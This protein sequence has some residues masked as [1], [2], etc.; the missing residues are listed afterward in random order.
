MSAI[1]EIFQT[2]GPEYLDHYEATIPAQHRK[3][4]EAIINCRT[5]A[6]GAAL[7]EC[8]RCGEPH[9]V[10]R[11]CGNRHCPNCQHHKSRQWLEKQMKRQLPTHHFMITFTVPDTLRPFVRSN[12]RLAYSAIFKASS[13]AIKKLAADEKYVGGDL[14]G[15]FGVLHTWGRQLHYHPHIHYVVPA[16]AL[17]TQDHRWHPSRIDFYLPIRALSK[18]FRA[19]FRDEMDKAGVLANIPAELWHIDW[20]VNCQPV[21]AGQHS[22]RYLAP[23][24]FKVAISD[25]RIIKVENRTVFFR[26]KKSHS[27]RWRTMTLEVMEFIRRFLHHVLPTGFMKIRYYGFMN[28]N[29]SVPLDHISALIQLAYG[30][31]VT[32]PEPGTIPMPVI[33]CALCGGTLRYRC[34]LLPGASSP[35]RPG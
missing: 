20:N 31:T 18:L 25:R 3:V 28:P 33:T 14:P 2:Y 1:K 7:Y 19:K 15:F 8:E 29:S 21:G 4:I 12:Q 30:F 11:S 34:L 26:Y 5:S 27:Q 10:Y 24:V 22:L 9:I 32:V 6:C 35:Q 17:S 13:E 16:G 23:Y